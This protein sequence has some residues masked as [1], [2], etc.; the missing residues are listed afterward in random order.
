MPPNHSAGYV[1]WPGTCSIIQG[2]D[3]ANEA[4]L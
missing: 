4:R 3:L 1:F 2:A